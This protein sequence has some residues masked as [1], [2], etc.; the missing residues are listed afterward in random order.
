[1]IADYCLDGAIRGARVI[2]GIGLLSCEFNLSARV[3]VT[4]EVLL[5]SSN[6]SLMLLRAFSSFDGLEACLCYPFNFLGVLLSS[7]LVTESD[8]ESLNALTLMLTF[9]AD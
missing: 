7:L 2:L 8:D 4:V 6:I 3:T 1:M 9:P 5:A